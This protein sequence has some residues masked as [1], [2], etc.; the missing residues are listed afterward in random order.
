[1]TMLRSWIYTICFLI[2]TVIASV[3]GLPLLITPA[4]ALGLT[5]FWARGV[6]WLAR[7]VVNITYRVEGKEHIPKGGC[8]IAAQH[9][10]SFETYLLFIEVEKP[11]FVFKREIIWIPLVSWYVLR[12]GLVPINRGA[13]A[14]AMRQ[15][16]RAAEAALERGSQ[17]LIFPE[18]TRTKPGGHTPYRPGVA[19]LY[20]HCRAPL[21]PMALNS[22]YYWGKTRIRKDAG[23]IV[24]R[25]LPPI[26]PGLGKDELLKTLRD[27]IEQA[28]ATLPKPAP[29]DPPA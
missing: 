24:F 11:V 20:A 28:S 22:G 6:M 25:F 2:W 19:G 3:G 18:G 10:S 5:R 27:R 21:I 23:E 1:M 26:E 17:I 9:Q 4:G 15:M 8:I 7:V 12:A 13:G 14:S 16:L 29:V